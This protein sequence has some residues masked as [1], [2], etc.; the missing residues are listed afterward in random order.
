MKQKTAGRRLLDQ[1]V[2]HFD[3]CGHGKTWAEDC[4]ECEVISLRGTI[5]NFEPM[6]SKAKQRLKE[7]EYE[8]ATQAA[9]K[10]GVDLATRTD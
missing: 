9:R 10:T 2:M 6:V 4:L 8:M 5:E 3:L 7:I 1:R